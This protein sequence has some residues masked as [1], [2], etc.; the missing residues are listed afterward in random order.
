VVEN[1]GEGNAI[2]FNSKYHGCPIKLNSVDTKP[3]D[4][5]YNLVVGFS[6]KEGPLFCFTLSNLGREL[7]G[8][9]DG[10]RDFSGVAFEFKRFNFLSVKVEPLDD[11]RVDS[12]R[13]ASVSIKASTGWESNWI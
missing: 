5:K 13:L 12:S 7:G 9:L 3:R 4:I 1:G 8:C 10:L 11:P 6:Y 2:V